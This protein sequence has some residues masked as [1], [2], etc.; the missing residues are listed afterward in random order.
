MVSKD[1]GTDTVS[2]L[3]TKRSAVA[4]YSPGVFGVLGVTPAIQYSWDTTQNPRKNETKSFL[5]LW[6]QMSLDDSH[7]PNDGRSARS[8]LL[9]CKSIAVR[10]LVKS[11]T[12]VPY[13]TS[14]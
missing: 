5:T 14:K 6:K 13:S 12:N 7:R 1:Y 2:L 3:R 10:R 8:M 4:T 9:F 11:S